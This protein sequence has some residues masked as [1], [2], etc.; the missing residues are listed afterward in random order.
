MMNNNKILTVS[1]GTFSCTL[2][3]FD[4]SFGTMK[5]IAEYFR[6]LSSE[7]RYFGAEPAQPDAEMLAHIAQKEISRRVE[8]RQQDGQIVLSA[9]TPE[10][11]AAPAQPTPAPEAAETPKAPAAPQPQVSSTAAGPSVVSTSFAP[12]RP[13]EI[14]AYYD[15][16]RINALKSAE[17]E[18]APAPQAEAAAPRDEVVSREVAAPKPEA[19]QAEAAPAPAAPAAEVDIVPGQ[20]DED[21]EAF[22]ADSPRNEVTVD[23]QDAEIQPVA[24]PVVDS[25]AAKLQRIRAVVAN[26]DAPAA[27]QPQ[28]FDDEDTIDAEDSTDDVIA[29]AINDIEGALDADDT[30]ENIAQSS[31]L[32]AEA[33]ED[34][35]TVQ[36]S[37]EQHEDVAADEVAEAD[38]AQ[39]EAVETEEA[40]EDAAPRG[41]VLKV[42]RADIDRAIAEGE[43]EEVEEDA[44]AVLEEP[45]K[46]ALRIQRDP[47][48][49]LSD[50]DEEDLARELAELEATLS[51]AA[52]DTLTD[53]PEDAEEAVA[54][55]DDA[56]QDETAKE[57]TA[58]EETAKEETA[59]EDSQEDTAQE[60]TLDTDVSEDDAEEV[61]AEVQA[62]TTAEPATEAPKAAPQ[63][64]SL[65]TLDA[66]SGPDM[67]RLLA[68]TD[69][70]MDEPEAAT[71]RDA[72]THLRAAV[73]AKKAD[74]ALGAPDAAERENNAYR[75]DLAEV[76][77]PRRPASTTARTERPAEPRPAPLKLVAAQRIDTDQPRN[78][79]PVRPRRVAAVAP[80][81]VPQAGGFA[82]FAEEMGATQLPDLLEAAAAYMAFV[83][84]MDDFSRPQ[85]MNT[86]RQGGAEDFSREEGLR[87]FGQLLRT[88]KLQKLEGG[89]F[90]AS[91]QI[92]FQPDARAAG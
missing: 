34:V 62:E 58:K 50:E 63:R 3:G 71:R 18:A 25:I 46:P 15:A 8:A 5:A 86:V 13:K 45:E 79:A 22:F 91:E 49:T 38:A 37:E 74:M 47:E 81:P 59:K 28:V 6:D 90:K 4:D 78:V 87:S 14:S 11:P 27:P 16:Y 40:E 36:E 17:A 35:T 10:E 21:V 23:D 41:R 31:D 88:G 80:A 7:D 65:P 53:A 12:R 75:S 83:E 24:A 29:N 26:Q 77:K 43:L 1:Y 84:G 61:Q 60:E 66:D 30:V 64:R 54:V 82:E 9:Q 39:V 76:V 56:P 44:P 69:N 85:L 2:E 68:E 51:S 52:A 33:E 92:G 89:R 48:S 72:I 55:E 67:N 19:T 57:E 42:K 73:A 70:Q 20:P 32:E